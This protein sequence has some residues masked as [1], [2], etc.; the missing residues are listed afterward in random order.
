[1]ELYRIETPVDAADVDCVVSEY[2]EDA[3]QEGE[4]K[5]PR[6]RERPGGRKRTDVRNLT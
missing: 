6:Q 2:M 3:W 1:M 4:P 5:G